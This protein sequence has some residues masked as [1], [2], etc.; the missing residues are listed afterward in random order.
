MIALMCTVIG[1]VETGGNWSMVGMEATEVTDLKKPT[2]QLNLGG[3]TPDLQESLVVHEFGHALGLE[4]E[5]QSSDFWDVVGEFL[6]VEKM[7]KDPQVSTA[8]EKQ[9]AR[10][11]STGSEEPSVNSLSEYDPESIMHYK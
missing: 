10:K 4:H 3:H 2:M 11:A 9:W 5:H 7:K 1:T 8:F 6:D